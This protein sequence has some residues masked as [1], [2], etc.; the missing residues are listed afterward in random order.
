M[1]NTWLL[2]GLSIYVSTPT[3]L[4]NSIVP[5]LHRL[6]MP[7]GNNATFSLPR[8]DAETEE[9]LRPR[10]TLFNCPVENLPP[11]PRIFKV[12]VLLSAMLQRVLNMT[13]DRGI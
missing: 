2:Q 10:Q 11:L 8:L 6:K 5:Q 13:Q 7:R 9:W 3:P 12:N 4:I 1:N